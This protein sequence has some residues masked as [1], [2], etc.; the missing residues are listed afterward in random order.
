LAEQDYD[1]PGYDKPGYDKP[2]FTRRALA[3]DALDVHR[4]ESEPV[5]PCE[6]AP[7]DH[8]HWTVFRCLSCIADALEFQGC[9]ASVADKQLRLVE[10]ARLT[11]ALIAKELA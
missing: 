11:K 6:G 7:E 2:K 8:P 5:A 10:A 4:K 1:K 3:E 9:R